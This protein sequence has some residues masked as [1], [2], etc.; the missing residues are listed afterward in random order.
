MHL[1]VLGRRVGRLAL[2]ALV[3]GCARASVSEAQSSWHGLGVAGVV[4]VGEF[5]GATSSGFGLSGLA[6]LN[7]LP[8]VAVR[9][10]ATYVRNT[11]G[12][13]GVCVFDPCQQ[14]GLTDVLE[15]GLSAMVGN[16]SAASIRVY[17]LGGIER[18]YTQGAPVWSGRSV[19]VP[20]V[21]AGV[22]FPRSAFVEL[23]GRW[24][25]EWEGW[26]I[27]HWVLLVGRYW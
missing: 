22:L 8:I 11:A 23:T 27:R 12:D 14:G 7:L 5:G 3:G 18:L 2:V 10:D 13:N 9:G 6:W 25:D 15:Y 19:V 26:R 21:G 1:R 16:M 4:H 24:R 20:K 17:A